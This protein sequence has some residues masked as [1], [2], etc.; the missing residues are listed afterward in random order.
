MNF[1]GKICA[2]ELS[3]KNENIFLR[4]FLR[5]VLISKATKCINKI[6][7]HINV[8]VIQ[9]RKRYLTIDYIFE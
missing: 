5:S 4:Y 1:Y 8:E 2:L 7:Q 3:K 9:K 6:P